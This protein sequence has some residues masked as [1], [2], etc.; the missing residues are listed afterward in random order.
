MPTEMDKSRI[1]S[2]LIVP[3]AATVLV[4][5]ESGEPKATIKDYVFAAL[6]GGVGGIVICV[7]SRCTNPRW[8]WLVLLLSLAI[9]VAAMIL[10]CFAFNY[11]PE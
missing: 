4:L 10:F 1:R 3:G 9:A 11:F 7:S 5:M 6:M 8:Q 2:W